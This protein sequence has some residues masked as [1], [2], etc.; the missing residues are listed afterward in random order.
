MVELNTDKVN[1]ATISV[2]CAQQQQLIALTRV[3]RSVFL[4]LS[5]H[6]QRPA[7][8]PLMQIML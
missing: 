6:S 5:H 7:L 2:K 1:T 8:D 3:H 4:Q